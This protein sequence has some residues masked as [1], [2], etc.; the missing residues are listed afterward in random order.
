MANIEELFFELIRVAIGYQGSL[1]S[2]PSEKEWDRLFILA[3]KQA[4]I[5]ICFA[6][7]QNLLESNTLAD[8]GLKEKQYL[9]WMGLATRIQQK[10]EVI[11][12]QCVKLQGKLLDDGFESVVLKGQGVAQLY[13]KRLCKLRQSGDIDLFLRS[14]MNQVVSYV[15]RIA[16]TNEINHKHAQL[17]IFDDTEVELHYIAAELHCPWQD[18]YLQ[19]FFKAHTE[20]KERELEGAGVILVPET[21]FN[22]VH[23][24][25]HSYRHLF[26]DGIGLRQ[27]MDLFFAIESTKNDGRNMSNIS[28]VVRKAGMGKFMSALTWVLNFVF[29][30]DVTKMPWE[31]NEKTGRF[32][33]N[34]ILATG[35]FG[36]YDTRIN[37]QSESRWQR[38]WR[39]T[40]QNLRLFQLAPWEVICTPIWRIWHFIW[41]RS[42]G[43]TQG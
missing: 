37:R 23:L 13:G 31:P 42:H 2:I 21:D 17:H 28:E 30:M 32:L 11:N 33:L 10:N 26:G 40:R 5:G 22:I 43:Y 15:Q 41:M 29:G 24:I 1:S 20:K 34:E 36:K 39:V 12:Q 7:I 38:F 9:T 4:L 6:G 14:E 16:P 35:N 19:D 3:Q 8:I 18:K 25:T 27:V